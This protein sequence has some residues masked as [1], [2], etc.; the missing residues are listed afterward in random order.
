MVKRKGEWQLYLNILLGNQS[1]GRK[2]HSTND[3][4]FILTL[5]FPLFLVPKGVILPAEGSAP[6]SAGLHSLTLRPERDGPRSPAPVWIREQP[7]FHLPCAPVL[8]P[9]S[10]RSKHVTLRQGMRTPVTR[11]NGGSSSG[12]LYWLEKREC[13]LAIL[14]LSHVRLL[15]WLLVL[16]PAVLALLPLPPLHWDPRR[17]SAPHRHPAPLKS[18]WNWCKN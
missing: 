4:V 14:P 7:S 8:C 15:C 11:T 2:G 16:C 6:S 18:Q 17:I 1:L 13:P 5:P 12:K 10:P 3:L 9:S